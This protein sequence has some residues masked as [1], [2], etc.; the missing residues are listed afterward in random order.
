MHRLLNTKYVWH[1]DMLF[2][3]FT[4][5]NLNVLLDKIVCITY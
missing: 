4:F 3:A 2:N 5:E 1:I